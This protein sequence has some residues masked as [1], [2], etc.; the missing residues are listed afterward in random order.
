ME[1]KT[2]RV[3]LKRSVLIG[4]EHAEADEIHKVSLDFGE[5]L[6]ACESA[7]P[8]F[9]D[10]VKRFVARRIERL[11]FVRSQRER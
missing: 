4:G 10:A 6:V 9:W 3:R 2:M 11:R 8:C 7:T 5:F 1:P